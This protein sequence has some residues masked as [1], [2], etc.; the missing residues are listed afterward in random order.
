MLQ[1]GQLVCD[2]CQRP[3]TRITEV[4]AEGW[5]RMHNLCSACFAAAKTKSVPR[6][7]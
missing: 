4:P 3:I 7:T 6:P 5:E 1:N 2:A